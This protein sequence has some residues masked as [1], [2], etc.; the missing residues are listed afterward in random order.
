MFEINLKSTRSNS[1]NTLHVLCA[2]DWANLALMTGP[3]DLHFHVEETKDQRCQVAYLRSSTLISSPHSSKACAL[4]L[5]D[6]LPGNRVI[7]IPFLL[8]KSSL[9]QSRRQKNFQQHWE[10]ILLITAASHSYCAFIKCRL[11]F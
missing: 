5:N 6:F 2:P 11:L 9:A 1:T 3:K 8:L 4:R 10:V 7:I